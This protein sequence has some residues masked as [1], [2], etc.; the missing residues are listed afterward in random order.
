MDRL[1]SNDAHGLQTIWFF[2]SK[3]FCVAKLRRGGGVR[4]CVF[5]HI[6]I[7]LALT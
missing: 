3:L 6:F 4:I 1:N 7:H 2:V 5:Q